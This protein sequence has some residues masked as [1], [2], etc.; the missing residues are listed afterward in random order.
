MRRRACFCGLFS[1]LA[2]IGGSGVGGMTAGV[3]IADVVV[4]LADSFCGLKRFKYD[5]CGFLCLIELSSK[6]CAAC[7]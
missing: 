3:S 7:G 4:V 5:S 6:I 1:A 2:T